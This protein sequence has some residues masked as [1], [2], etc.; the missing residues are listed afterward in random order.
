MGESGFFERLRQSAGSVWDDYVQHPF[1]TGIA[2]GSLPE[3]A[4]RHYLGQDYLFLLQFARAYALAVYKSDSLDAMRAEAAGMSAILDVET[5][6][7]VFD[8]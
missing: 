3:P 1:V 8:M 4:F 7:H 2:D 5:H 6:L